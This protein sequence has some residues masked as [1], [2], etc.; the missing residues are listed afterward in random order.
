TGT[1]ET[2]TANETTTNTG[3]T[4]TSGAT[5]SPR[6][7]TIIGSVIGGVGTLAGLVIILLLVR[8]KWRRELLEKVNTHL[9]SSLPPIEPYVIEKSPI[10]S[11]NQES[12]DSNLDEQGPEER[13]RRVSGDQS[14]EPRGPEAE[15]EEDIENRELPH[16]EEVG[17]VDQARFSAMQTQIGLLMQRV[18]RIEATEQ[19]EAPPE[20]VSAYGGSQ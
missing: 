20:Y 15:F 8:R 7:T 4:D 2:G 14:A 16:D 9:L 5:S 11:S 12:I 13:E 18:E 19:S 17:R 3:G 1:I 6:T 10:R